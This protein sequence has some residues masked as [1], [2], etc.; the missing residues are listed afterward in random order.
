MGW[1]YHYIERLKLGE[2]VSFRPRG[3]SMRG[4]VNPGQL[5]T[6][7]PADPT[8]IKNG[9]VV[10]CRV[11]GNEY[12]HIVKA[13]RGKG[14]DRTFLIGNNKGGTNGWTSAHQVFGKLVKI[15]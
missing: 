10:L 6:L 4:R 5:C 14:I 13:I 3:E 9:D 7:E 11:S 2:T 12:L 8:S 1:A 15:E